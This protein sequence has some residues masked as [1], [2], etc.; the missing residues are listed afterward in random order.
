MCNAF[1]PSEFGCKTVGLK[2]V[3]KALPRLFESREKAVRDEARGLAVEVYRWIGGALRPALQ[4]VSPVLLRELEEEWARLPATPTT[5]TRFLRSQQHLRDAS[6]Q[7]HQQAEAGPHQADGNHEEDDE[8]RNNKGSWST[9]RG[10][11]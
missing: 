2:A 8:D 11:I 6:L 10:G 4:G 3:V 7:Q 9:Y 5:Q 1:P